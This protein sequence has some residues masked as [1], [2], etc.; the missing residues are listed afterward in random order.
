LNEDCAAQVI[1]EVTDRAL[2]RPAEAVHLVD[3][4]G[5]GTGHSAPVQASLVP[6]DLLPAYV[7]AV[8]VGIEDTLDISRATDAEQAA[9]TLMC[10][11]FNVASGDP[12]DLTQSYDNAVAAGYIEVLEESGFEFARGPGG[13]ILVVGGNYATSVLLV[14]NDCS[15]LRAASPTSFGGSMT[16]VRLLDGT[17]AVL[18]DQCLNL[19]TPI[20][21]PE[22]TPTPP[23][24]GTPTPTDTPGPSPTPTETP[25][26]PP[27]PTPT[28]TPRLK[29]PPP[30]PTPPPSTQTPR[31]TSTPPPPCCPDE[32]ET[33]PAEGETPIAPTF[34]PTPTRTPLPQ[35][36]Q[37]RPDPPEPTQVGVW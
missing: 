33:P 2:P 12:A 11:G 25:T 31:P 34:T 23:K 26:P 19:V 16:I 10:N 5:W 9:F 14:G 13:E 29:T 22:P 7:S 30:T 17:L 27:T 15:T 20:K 4:D 18:D 32:E 24:K 3:P 1:I 36:T 8:P 21:K 37:D 28:E 6:T 35:P